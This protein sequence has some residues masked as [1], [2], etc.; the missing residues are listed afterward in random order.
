MQALCP[1]RS[2]LLVFAFVAALAVLGPTGRA[3]AS[4]SKASNRVVATTTLPSSW[5]RL[6][7]P[8]DAL[9]PRYGAPQNL[10]TTLLGAAAELASDG[11]R[12]H[13]S[14][15]HG[16]LSLHAEPWGFGGVLTLRYR[17]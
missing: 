9:G 15:E 10:A 5:V 1:L 14:P 8:A 11:L 3:S 6:S 16:S 12:L 13:G 17:R 7:A 4:P 2:I